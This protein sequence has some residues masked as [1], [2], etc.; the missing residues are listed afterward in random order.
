[1][2]EVPLTKGQV[3]L[4]DDEDAERVLAHNWCARKDRGIWYAV[5]T[6]RRGQGTAYMLMHR[7]ILNAPPGMETD[8]INRNGLDN[9]RLNLRLVTTS[10]NQWNRAR[11]FNNQT[12]FKGVCWHKRRK[13][14][15]AKTQ[16]HG[17][18]LHIGSF[19]TAIEAARAYDATT[20]LLRGEFARVNFPN[21][22]HQLDP[23]TVARLLNLD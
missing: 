12:G 16:Q 2:I 14:F 3:A 6:Y 21:E 13:K 17:V 15:Y 22:V 19:D 8:H 1:M 7:L 20:R 18:A 9:R 10:Q 5:R 11:N 4:I 23:Q